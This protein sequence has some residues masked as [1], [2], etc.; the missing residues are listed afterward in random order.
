MAGNVW[1]S[2]QLAHSDQHEGEGPQEGVHPSRIL[3]QEPILPIEPYL[4]KFPD[5]TE[6]TSLAEDQAFKN[7]CGGGAFHN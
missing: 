6:R 7:E 5:P 2:R 3:D 1:W 4:L